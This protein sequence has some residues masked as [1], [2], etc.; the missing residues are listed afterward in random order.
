MYSNE[1]DIYDEFK[2]K[3]PIGLQ[4]LDNNISALPTK[5]SN[6]NSHTLEI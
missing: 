6:L 1:R 5:V 3:N 2:S 4:G